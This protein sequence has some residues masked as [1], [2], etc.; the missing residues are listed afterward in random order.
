MRGWAAASGPPPTRPSSARSRAGTRATTTPEISNL[1]RTPANGARP[2]GRCARSPDPDRDPHRR[3]RAD[4]G[5]YQRP[6]SRHRGA[7]QRIGWPPRDPGLENR[8]GPRGRIG[9]FREVRQPPTP[10]VSPSGERRRS[11]TYQR[12]GYMR[13]PVLKMSRVRLWKRGHSCVV[14]SRATAS[15]RIVRRPPWPGSEGAGRGLRDR[16]PSRPIR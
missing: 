2:G 14:P 6:R 10:A 13:L 12:M 1:T 16:W 8:E 5:Q 15:I 11:R 3:V 7:G 9:Q 4:R